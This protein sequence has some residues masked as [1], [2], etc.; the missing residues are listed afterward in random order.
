[1]SVSAD[2]GSA[3][4]AAGCSSAAALEELNADVSSEVCTTKVISEGAKSLSSKIWR[5]NG[6]IPPFLKLFD[7]VSRA[8]ARS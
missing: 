5:S 4:S 3:L 1:M 2:S 8:A 7:D 6:H